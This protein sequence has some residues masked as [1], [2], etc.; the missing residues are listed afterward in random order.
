MIISPLVL[1]LGMVR[2]ATSLLV[3]MLANVLN[4]V[5][6]VE[7]Q[8]S[9]SVVTFSFAF[10]HLMTPVGLAAGYFSDTR[11]IWGWRRL[12]YI[13]GGMA[14]ALFVMPFFPLWG[15]ALAVAP[16]SWVVLYQG[17]LLF[18]LFGV[19]TT[20]SA[21]AINALL[22]D[23][24]PEA[25]RGAALTLVWIMTLAGFIV[26]SSLLQHLLPLYNPA[27]LDEVF[28]FVTFLALLITLWGTWG[29]E[30]QGGVTQPQPPSFPRLWPTLQLLAGN[31]QALIFFAF[32]WASVF[33]LAIQSFIITSYGGEVLELPVAETT[34]F[35]IYTSYGILIGMVGINLLMR[36]WQSLGDKTILAGGLILSSLA[37]GLLS[38]TSFWPELSL[39]IYS[40]WLLG[41]ARGLFNVGISYL[42]MSLAP[43]ACSG[44]FMGLWNL[45]S[46][47]GLAGGEMAGGI[48]RDQGVQRLGS[49]HWAY[50]LVFLLEGVGLLSCLAL[51]IPLNRERYWQRYTFL[52]AS[53]SN[54]PDNFTEFAKITKNPEHQR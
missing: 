43:A 49:V 24:I 47:L 54:K 33:F 3:V 32:L 22:V 46:G 48:L 13:W 15:R 5:L 36:R 37:F 8:V 42:T 12:P 17:V 14:L 41:L 40:L 16:H 9:A 6:I 45:V 18:S 23:Q 25:E 52:V 53:R 2:F 4:R 7:L 21:T 19:G 44:V 28:G 27:Y 31:G 26:G 11:A 29:V 50:G 1:K 38:L 51:L 35:G 34:R 39:G 10:Q 30:G 20:V